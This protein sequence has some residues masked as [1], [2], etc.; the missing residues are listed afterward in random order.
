VAVHDRATHSH[1]ERLAW[2]RRAHNAAAATSRVVGIDGAARTVV[3][4]WPRRGHRKRRSSVWRPRTGERWSFALPWRTSTSPERPRTLIASRRVGVEIPSYAA[5][6]CSGSCYRPPY[7]RPSGH[8]AVRTASSAATVQATSS[9]SLFAASTSALRAPNPP[10]FSAMSR[11]VPSASAT[12]HTAR[13]G[14]TSP[15]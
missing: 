1:R 13:P 2:A 4:C 9:F 6:S 11:R 12:L 10:G 7:T 8:Q 15:A 5:S 3:A 14:D